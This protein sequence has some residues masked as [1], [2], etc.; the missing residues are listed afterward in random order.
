MDEEK[1]LN[2][3]SWWNRVDV[4]ELLQF[5]TFEAYAAHALWKLD[6]IEW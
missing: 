5:L 3:K 4:L 6:E 2:K 1:K